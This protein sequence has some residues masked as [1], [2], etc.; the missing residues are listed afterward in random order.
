[1]L[2]NMEQI[3]A[4][5]ENP[6]NYRAFWEGSQVTV[7]IYPAVHRAGL[8]CRRREPHAAMRST[9][10]TRPC[11]GYGHVACLLRSGWLAAATNVIGDGHADL[12]T[13]V[14]ERVGEFMNAEERIL[15]CGCM[16]TT[17]WGGGKTTASPAH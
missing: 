8:L 13:L 15:R 10:L 6:L 3:V 11:S 7:A 12:Y 4:A 5:G 1:M 16:R 2:Q 9:N 17:A 14:A